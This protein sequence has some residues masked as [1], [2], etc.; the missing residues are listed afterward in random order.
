M[1]DPHIPGGRLRRAKPPE[2]CQ[3]PRRR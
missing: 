1:S 2:L 3:S